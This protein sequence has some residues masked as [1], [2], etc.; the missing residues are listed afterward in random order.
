VCEAELAGDVVATD[1]EH[2]DLAEGPLQVERRQAA[3]R[4][5]RLNARKYRKK[6]LSA[7]RE[8]AG[9]TKLGVGGKNGK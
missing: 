6:G 1:G 9:K 4:H 3:P 5:I 2:L 7:D 8:Q